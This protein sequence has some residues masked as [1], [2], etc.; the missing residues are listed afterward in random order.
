MMRPRQDS[1]N[2]SEALVSTMSKSTFN[3]GH[4]HVVK[5]TMKVGSRPR[6][7]T[8]YLGAVGGGYYQGTT[9][10]MRESTATIYKS[11]PDS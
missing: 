9:A 8:D 2:R 7:T 11:R 4:V 6:F 1:L 10:Q 5:L 3:S